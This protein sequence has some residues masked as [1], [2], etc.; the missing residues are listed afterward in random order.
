MT[1]IS[2]QKHP[3]ST[4]FLHFIRQILFQQPQLI[5][6]MSGTIVR[7]SLRCWVTIPPSGWGKVCGCSLPR[8]QQSLQL[9]FPQYLPGESVSPRLGQVY[10]SQSKNWLDIQA[11]KLVVNRAES[12]QQLVTSGITQGSELGPAL[13]IV[14]INDLDE[15]T[16]SRFADNI[17]L[18]GSNLPEGRK[19][20]QKDLDRL[21]Q[22]AEAN[23]MSLTRP[24]AESYS[25]VSTTSCIHASVRVWSRVVGKLHKGSGGGSWQPDEC[26]PAMFPGEQE[27]QWHPDS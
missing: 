16:L 17:K 10:S 6:G 14:F 23:C 20:L 1:F 19:A 4:E 22:W 21:D 3:L 5:H 15:C 2:Y 11:Q 7:Y 18:G 26:E 13:F 9:C 25:S 12:S 27:G 8:L 24:S